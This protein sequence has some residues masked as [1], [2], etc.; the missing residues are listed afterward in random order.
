R[1]PVEAQLRAFFA[2]KERPVRSR[3]VA[4]GRLDLDDVGAKLTEQAGAELPL[5]VG[6]V[7]HAVA[8][9]GS[10]GVGKRYGR[11]RGHMACSTVPGAKS[12]A[13]CRARAGSRHV[14]LSHEDNPAVIGPAHAAG[15][16]DEGAATAD[17]RDAFRVIVERWVDD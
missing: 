2:T 11:S 4:A 5:L 8:R 9:K 3:P 13:V 6:E 16:R 1:P 10:T 7:E 12:E 14:A 15:I 17:E